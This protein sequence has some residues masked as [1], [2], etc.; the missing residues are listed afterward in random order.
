M[1]DRVSPNSPPQRWKTVIGIVSD[2]KNSGLDVPT[3]PQ[4]FV[5]GV[6]YP[7]STT[8]QLVVRSIGD[9]HALES[10]I[11]DKLR[12]LDSGLIANF[13]PLADIVAEM[14]GGARFN[15]V[16]VGSFAAIAFLMAMS[17]CTAC[18]RSL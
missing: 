10:A 13:Q 11:A 6:T 4:V 9:Q 18:S 14:S 8:L 7:V 12:S 15:A 3:A 5:N 17:V 1:A 2:S 16:L